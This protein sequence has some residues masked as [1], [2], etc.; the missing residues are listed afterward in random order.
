M[1][2][3]Q[4]IR[5]IKHINAIKKALHGRDQLLFIFGINSGLRI[6]DI[7]KIKVGDVRDKDSIVVQE[8]KT[9]KPKRFVFNHSIKNAVSEIVP[10]TA[11]DNEY[12]FKSRK[13]DNKPISRVAAWRILNDAADRAGVADKIGALGTHSLRKSF[14]Y[15]AYKNGTDIT[16][17]QSIFNH[18]SQKDT[19]RYI[20]INQDMID[21]VYVNINL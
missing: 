5:N 20:G 1:N 15:H 17:L 3:V 4:P 8:T 16:L 18:S 13:G 14:G 11:D 2:E 10:A 21:E 9:S 19:L 6:S 7:L 12:L